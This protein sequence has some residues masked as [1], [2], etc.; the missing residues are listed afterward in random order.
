MNLSM[1][2]KRCLTYGLQISPHEQDIVLKK[3]E[4][5]KIPD[6]CLSELNKDD[7][8]KYIRGLYLSGQEMS[9]DWTRGYSYLKELGFI[10]KTRQ[11]GCRT[12][13]RLEFNVS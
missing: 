8:R 13:V 3:Y 1:L 11:E 5:Y 12:F 4:D 9:N 7:L 6:N 2:I 10:E